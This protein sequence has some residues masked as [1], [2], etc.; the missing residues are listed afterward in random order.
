MT[1]L[2]R[3]LQLAEKLGQSQ[4]SF[5]EAL[6]I[7]EGTLSSAKKRGSDVGSSML[8]MV[9]KAYPLV[10]LDWLILGEGDML[11]GNAAPTQ[12]AIGNGNNQ[13][14]NLADCAEKLRERDLEIA[15]LKGQVNL[16][17]ELLNSK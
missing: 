13:V 17:K 2:Q 12:T 16:L 3:I 9:K 6:G 14:M 1:V 4:R 7:S 15:A 11:I 8:A 10:S 5:S